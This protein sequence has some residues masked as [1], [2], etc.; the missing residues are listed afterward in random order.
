MSYTPPPPP[1]QGRPG[2]GGAP[3]GQ[4]P[5]P[6]SGL[7][8]AALVVGIVAVTSVCCGLFPFGGTA[9]VVLGTLATVFGVNGRRGIQ[10]SAGSQSGAGMAV[11][12]M[13]LGIVALVLGAALVVLYF[14][15]FFVGGGGYP[16]DY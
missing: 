6:T 12:G 11:A 9:A 2:Y 13:V 16:V 5:A 3:Q 15:F 8:V 14:I 4:V 7:A 10:R 1:D